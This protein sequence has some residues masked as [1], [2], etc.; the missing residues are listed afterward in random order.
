MR[1]VMSR[2]PLVVMFSAALAGC[3]FVAGL[4]ESSVRDAGDEPDIDASLRQY[5]LFV[6]VA[7][8]GSVTSEPAGIDCGDDCSAVFDE[9]AMVTLTATAGANAAFA[10]WSGDGCSGST[11]VCTV[12]MTQAR[13]IAATFKPGHTLTVVREGSGTIT[14]DPAGIDCGTACIHGYDEGTMVTLT[15]VPAADGLFKGW[16]GDDGGCTDDGSTC[17]VTMDRARTVTAKFAARYR[18]TVTTQGAGSVTANVGDVVSFTCPANETCTKDFEANTNV[19]LSGTADGGFAFREWSG[20]CA[21]AATT[22]SITMSEPMTTTVVF[23]RT[24]LLTVTTTGTGDGGV[25]IREEGQT[26]FRCG[27]T[28]NCSRTYKEG[29]T[30]TLLTAHNTENTGFA[31]WGGA[32]GG[33]ASSCMVVIR[34]ATTVTA[35]FRAEHL[36]VVFAQLISGTRGSGFVR[37]VSGGTTIGTCTIA[38]SQCDMRVPPGTV[39]VTAVNETCGIFQRWTFFSGE[40]RAENPL[41]FTLDRNNVIAAYFAGCQ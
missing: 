21:Q 9:G 34:Q 27:S 1:S 4:E 25:T 14:S 18:L 30:L 23:V 26:D 38:Q 32:C 36:L 39:T 13:S 7:G 37:V 28:T 3:Q 12:T 40:T 35:A 41:S 22:C 5:T 11:P 6:A 15:A 17:T 33:T 19:V 8:N 20:A 24:Y 31:G 16:S 2:L 10:E 29:T